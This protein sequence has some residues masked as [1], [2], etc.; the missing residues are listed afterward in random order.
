MREIPLPTFLI[1]G[2]QKS[3]TQW[4]RF[5]L[6]RH[7]EVFS[8][9]GEPAFFNNGK[10][11]EKFGLAWYRSQFAGWSGEPIIGES[12]PGYMFWPHRPAE[13]ADRIRTVLPDVQLIAILR[14][15]VDR[16]QSALIHHIEMGAL[17]PDANLLDLVRGTPPE[18]EPRG[19]VA[20][21]WYAASLEPYLQRFGDRL[22]VLIHNDAIRDPYRLYDHVLR[23]VGAW[24]GFMPPDL[25]VYRHTN[26]QQPSTAPNRAPLTTA[27]REELYS[28][29]AEDIAKLQLLI[30]RDLSVWDP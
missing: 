8:A 9:A 17:A 21:G 16:A 19:I 25:E 14:N 26:R 30:G 28:Y 6:G 5:N 13:I 4:L 18:H 11:Y 15:P 27:E 12:T 7:P 20:G 3:A 24:G 2:A 29:F 22:L 1:I 10:H 23:H